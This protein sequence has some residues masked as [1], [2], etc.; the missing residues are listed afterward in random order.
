MIRFLQD[1]TSF[2]QAQYDETVLSIKEARKKITAHSTPQERKILLYCIDTLHEIIGE[3]DPKKIYDFADTIHNIPEIY[4][5]ERDLYSFRKELDSFRNKYGKQYFPFINE[6]KPRFTK[7]APKKWQKFFLPSSDNNFK[8]IHPTVYKWLE[9]A[10]GT[11]FLLPSTIY[12]AY[13]VFINRAPNEWWMLLGFVGTM[14]IGIGL[15]NI[16]AAWVHQ[17][18]GH[19]F[20]TVCFLVGGGIAALSLYFLYT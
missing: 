8:K 14:I 10:G 11:A 13:T 6:V 20:T 16:V 5:Q 1:S 18:L 9:A 7:K 12:A 4:T 2:D 19:F 3:G 15:F 17:Y